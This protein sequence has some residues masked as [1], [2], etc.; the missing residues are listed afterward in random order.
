MAQRISQ[1]R[2]QKKFPLR[3]RENPLF[4]T[5]SL[6]LSKP[7]LIRKESPIVESSSQHYEDFLHAL[8]REPTPAL[9]ELTRSAFGKEVIREAKRQARSHF[10]I[11]RI[12][13]DKFEFKTTVLRILR[14]ESK[15]QQNQSKD[16]KQS[17][18]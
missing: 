9:D 15:N 2:K 13:P 3:R 17:N 7:L 16:S 5:R 1:K 12:K 18:L 11:K 8:R 14:G 6:K 10:K 4:K